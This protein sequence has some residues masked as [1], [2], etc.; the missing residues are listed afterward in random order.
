[1]VEPKA[2]ELVIPDEYDEI[3]LT[4]S[5]EGSL[6]DG[7]TIDKIMESVKKITQETIEP[8]AEPNAAELDIAK[9]SKLVSMSPIK[10]ISAE[11]YE[12]FRKATTP[13]PYMRQHQP[14]SNDMYRG[15]YQYFSGFDITNKRGPIGCDV[16]IKKCSGK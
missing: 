3:F 9:P 1:M 5:Y 13:D 10:G 15:Y 8:T 12:L 7:L 2:A 16:I 11:T 6:S 4:H 14:V